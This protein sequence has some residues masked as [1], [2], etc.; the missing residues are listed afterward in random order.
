MEQPLE[1]AEME[2]VKEFF[3]AYWQRE[4]PGR[5]LVG[6][7]AP[8]DDA[9]ER[10]FPVP[11]TPAGKM[12]D[13]GYQR[14]EAVWRARNTLYLGEAFPMAL[15][16]IGPDSFTAYLGGELEF[17]NEYTS[18]IR[19]FVDDLEDYAPAFDRDNRWWRHMCELIDALC[20]AA[21]GNFLVGIPDLH[22]GGDALAAMRHPDRLALD[23]YDKPAE[24]KRIM[25]ALTEIYKEIFDAY[26]ERISRV[27]EGCTTWLR[28]YSR[29][30]Y[31]ALQNDFSGL[32]SPEMFVEF[33]LPDV[34]Q[35]ARYLDNSLYHLDGPAALG[36][37]PHLLELEKLDGIQWV[38]GAGAGTMG[39]WVEVCRRVLEAGKCL[40]VGCPSAELLPLLE[41]LPHEG[42]CLQTG[43]GSEGDARRLLARV[44]EEFGT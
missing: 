7:T 27:Q 20:E 28:A 3:D 5:P 43:C 37:L 14:N 22:G 4:V 9:E 13:V 19:P 40:F 30:T 16:N 34:Q 15:P 11:E 42:L 12:T 2:R 25:S 1:R 31:T 21:P 10:G 29:G 39:E 23:L 26:E 44:E 41:Q 17:V 33:F 35:M 8:L 24:V 6:I 32:V 36:N 38:P 18:W